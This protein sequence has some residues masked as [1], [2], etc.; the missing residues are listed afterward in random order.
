MLEELSIFFCLLI[1]RR[2]REKP[3]AR[4]LANTCLAFFGLYIAYIGAM[5]AQSTA[6]VVLSALL[7]YMFLVG[8][9]SLSAEILYPLLSNRLD[10]YSTAYF[11]TGVVA[12]WGELRHL[13]GIP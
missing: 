10:Q 3:H 12:S 6:C 2:L 5:Y 4:L 9:V 8:L 13:K 11:V 7:N 1:H